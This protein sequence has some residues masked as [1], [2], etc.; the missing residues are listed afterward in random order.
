MNTLKETPIHRQS[1]LFL[2][3]DG[4]LADIAPRPQE[5]C[6]APSVLNDLRRLHA[7]LNGAVA[8]ITG[9]TLGEIQHFLHPLKLAG[10]YEH[11]AVRNGSSGATTEAPQPALNKVR[12]AAQELLQ[13]HPRLLV[14][15]KGAGVAVHYR[16]A[17][18][19]HREVA[20]MLTE[21]VAQDCELQLLQGKSVL[22]IKSV[23]V[24]KGRAIDAFM[25]E[26]PFQG[27]TPVFVGD[28]VTD[29]SG[30]E[31]VQRLGG[32]GIKIGEGSTAARQ[33]IPS[34][35]ELRQ[36]LRSTADRLEATP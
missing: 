19:L 8:I 33:R 34:P 11:G 7:Q 27:R 26:T 17:P 4:T 21:L 10:A 30:F 31:T 12:A 3:F 36:W 16:Q 28:D 13:R 5:V 20:Q 2:D 9:R 29:E 6:V 24:G 35:A 32:V 23:H 22:E 18:E 1:A 25:L 14:E 15:Q